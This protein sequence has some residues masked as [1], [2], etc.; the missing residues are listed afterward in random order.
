M[1]SLC[2]WMTNTDHVNIT[3][4]QLNTDHVNITYSQLKDKLQSKV[5]SQCHITLWQPTDL[6][7]NVYWFILADVL[8]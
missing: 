7:S 4:S 1:L 3:Y 5:A 8:S 2:Y 6:C